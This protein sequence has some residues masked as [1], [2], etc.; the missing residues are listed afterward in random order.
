[1]NKFASSWSWLLLVLCA[2][3]CSRPVPRVT[4][5]LERTESWSPA[6]V[7]RFG[8]LP[9][10]DEG[11]VM[12][13]S[14]LAAFTLYAVHGRRDVQF[15]TTADGGAETK[16]KLS[17]TEWLLDVWCFPRQSAWYPLFRIENVG[18]LSELGF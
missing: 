7:E 3:A 15:V 1:M 11:R 18:V 12:P 13:L 8:S 9:L 2:V 5:E 6:F 17:P 10:Q 4:T 14:T 16:H